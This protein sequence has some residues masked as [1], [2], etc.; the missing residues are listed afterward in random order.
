MNNKQ[1]IKISVR[2]IPG[3]VSVSVSVPVGSRDGRPMTPT[4]VL[5]RT[6]LT[7]TSTL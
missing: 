1:I 2:S 7:G 4:T 5:F 3:P 6:T